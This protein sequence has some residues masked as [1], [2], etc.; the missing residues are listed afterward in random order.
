[1]TAKKLPF[2]KEQLETI[3][4]NHPTPFHIYDEKAMRENARYFNKAFSWNEGFK[5]YYAI[6][7][8]PNPYL[9][10]ILREEGFG[11]DCS[12]VAELELAK[13]VGMSGDEI[14]L[15]SNDT[16][17]YEFQLAEDL[18]AIINLD[19]I[20]HIDYL[21][22]HVGLPKTICMR[23]NP[24]SLKQG[25]LIIGHPEEAKYGFT[26]EQIIEGYRI[27]KE[28]GV[29]RFGIHTMVASN[30]LDPKYFVETA[31]ILFNLI[32]EVY[33][34]TG[35]RI[36]FA[37]LGGG[38]GIPY[39]PGEQ[40]VDLNFVSDGIKK[41]Y[42]E[43][44]VAKGLAP[45]KIFFELGRAI[46]GPYGYL[47]TKVRHIKKTYKSFAG[48][49]AC[50]ANLMRPALYGAYH[51]ITVMGKEN[52]PATTKYDVTGS[53]CENNDKF[54]IDRML[55]EI[56]PDDIVVIHDTG[57]HGHSMGFNYN[58]KLRSAELL[59][60]ENGDVIEIRRAET[61]EDYFA[62]LDFSGVKD[63]K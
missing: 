52:E 15:T 33:E 24:G 19:D 21:E 14:I 17:A 8:A 26:R 41:L 37:N 32:D 18:G 10:K 44:I 23:Y 61:L 12:S 62:T 46:T 11:I 42:D 6:K 28:K 1:M 43:M 13:Q 40:P 20:S 56:D 5:E 27:L 3:I 30:E 57:A 48:L 60:R 50:M 59:L 25:N 58:G 35:V 45:L 34:K 49:D 31:E 22:K 7:S 53:L 4:A 63:F 54:A 39:K 2:S 47:V 9:M 51:H 36:E 29:E 16:P 38:V 55:P